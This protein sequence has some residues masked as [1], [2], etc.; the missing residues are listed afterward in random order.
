MNCI[1]N[2]RGLEKNIAQDINTFIKEKNSKVPFDANDGSFELDS[3]NFDK[4]YNSLLDTITD[5]SAYFKDKYGVTINQDWLKLSESSIAIRMPKDVKSK[6]V[7]EKQENLQDKIDLLTGIKN[8]INSVNTNSIN[9]LIVVKNRVDMALSLLRAIELKENGV[10]S[11]NILKSTGWEHTEKSGWI[12][13]KLGNKDL[14]WNEKIDIYKDAKNAYD[15][16]V[17]LKDN[18]YDNETRV[19]AENL[20]NYHGLKGVKVSYSWKKIEDKQKSR[21]GVLGVYFSANNEIV[22]SIPQTGASFETTSIH[23]IIHAITTRAL[24]FEPDFYEKIH[25]LYEIAK[26]RLKDK[27][28]YG[29]KNEHEFVAEALSNLDFIEELKNIEYE[30]KDGIKIN[31]FKKFI[32][33]LL[34]IFGGLFKT[35]ANL[36]DAVISTIEKYASVLSDNELREKYSKEWDVEWYLNQKK[37]TETYFKEEDNDI[38]YMPNMSS[39]SNTID[40]NMQALIQNQLNQ[41]NSYINSQL[42]QAQIVQQNITSQQFTIDPATFMARRSRSKSSV[43]TINEFEGDINQGAYENL[44]ENQIEQKKRLLKRLENEYTALRKLKQKHTGDESYIEKTAKYRDIIKFTKNEIITLEE[45]NEKYLRN[46][47]SIALEAEVKHLEELVGVGSFTTLPDIDDVEIELLEERIDTISK[48]ILGISITGAQA[49][50]PNGSTLKWED[51]VNDEIDISNYMKRVT[52]I[53]N[54][55]IEKRERIIEQKINKTISR[56]DRIEGE[57]N[58]EDYVQKIMEQLRNPQEMNYLLGQFNDAE[59]RLGV[60]GQVIKRVFREEV[61]RIANPIKSSVS[62]IEYLIQECKKLDKNFSVDFLIQ[63]DENG[64]STPYLNGIYNAN[65]R[66]LFGQLVNLANSY[67][68]NVTAITNTKQSQNIVNGSLLDYLKYLKDNFHIFNPAEVPDILSV[69]KNYDRK[70]NTD[71]YH[72]FESI[73]VQMYGENFLHQFGIDDGDIIYNT[74]I[75]DEQKKKIE[76]YLDLI[77]VEEE[78]SGSTINISEDT[79]NPFVFF[80]E[81]E[82]YK[83]GNANLL[84]NKNTID[85]PKIS[86]YIISMP[87]SESAYNKDLKGIGSK[88][89]DTEEEKLADLKGKLWKATRDF[90]VEQINPAFIALGANI[91][92]YEIPLSFSSKDS[93]L[94]KTLGFF[95]KFKVWI[96]DILDKISDVFNNRMYNDIQNKPPKNE[97]QRPSTGEVNRL[98]NERI[99]FLTS[100]K[101]NT[102]KNKLSDLEVKFLDYG[103]FIENKGYDTNLLTNNQKK[104]LQKQYKRYLADL[105]ARKEIM[106]NVNTNFL[107][108]IGSLAQQIIIATARVNTKAFADTIVNYI[109]EIVNRQ[110]DITPA[111]NYLKLLEQWVYRN[112]Y[113]DTSI[114]DKFVGSWMTS[115]VGAKASINKKLTFG[116]RISKNIFS[117][118]KIDKN[119]NVINIPDQ[120]KYENDIYSIKRKIKY[121]GVLS[122]TEE[123]FLDKLPAE[124]YDDYE[125]GTLKSVDIGNET[126]TI[127][128]TFLKNGVEDSDMDY[129][130][131]TKKYAES[132]K[133]QMD[134]Y[135]AYRTV[136]GIVLGLMSLTTMQELGINPESGIRNR[137]EGQ[138]KNN[139]FAAS[140]RYGFNEIDLYRARRFLFGMNIVKMSNS[141]KFSNLILDHRFKQTKVFELWMNNLSIMQNHTNFGLTGDNEKH[142]L[143]KFAIDIPETYNQGEIVLALLGRSDIKIKDING[144]EF[145]IFDTQKNDF[146]IYDEEAAVRGILRLKPEFRTEEN[147]SQW[148]KFEIDNT[149]HTN[150]NLIQQMQSTITRIQ[151]NYEDIDIMPIQ[152]SV[153][154][155]SII[156]YKRWAGSHFSQKFSEMPIDYMLSKTSSRGMMNV[157]NDHPLLAISFL[158]LNSFLGLGANLSQAVFNIYNPRRFF[159]I[160]VK[161]LVQTGISLAAIKFVIKDQAKPLSRDLKDEV[162]LLGSLI[163]EA[164]GR[165]AKTS[166]S[167]VSRRTWDSNYGKTLVDSNYISQEDRAVISELA[168]QMA[169]CVW[170]LLKTSALVLLFE[171]ISELFD[172]QDCTGDDCDERPQ[173]IQKYINFIINAEHMLIID[174]LKWSNPVKWWDDMGSVSILRTVDR[175]ISITDVISNPTKEPEDKWI[176]I[177]KGFPQPIIPNQFLNP[178]VVGIANLSKGNH[179]D[180]NLELPFQDNRIYENYAIDWWNKSEDQKVQVKYNSYNKQLK[181]SATI[182]ANKVIKQYQREN[183][184][185]KPKDKSKIKNELIESFKKPFSKPKNVD[186]DTFVNDLDLNDLSVTAR[187]LARQE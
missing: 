130:K 53:V 119:G 23:E 88:N 172:L 138:Y 48:S 100:L 140:G 15:L 110:S 25:N 29:L 93:E 95:D 173:Y 134:N 131:Y 178:L 66:I 63:K 158:S 103:D 30:D 157:L 159:T 59:Q 89:T 74:E 56:D 143:M 160:I 50:L 18:A 68:K 52:N 121:E 184:S 33:Y 44:I 170:I 28:Y 99:S 4:S 118:D 31:I 120:F 181:K 112:V 36:H 147:I 146:A 165:T 79:R 175:W 71:F 153:V 61:F 32:D 86:D 90:L 179:F 85:K 166:I 186:V 148:E 6:I 76:E 109:R 7:N 151:G 117:K 64:I 49:I 84:T 24:T 137:R 27:N 113:G 162:R 171:V 180:T 164:I 124:L 1:N 80:R 70:N 65:G 73:V 133:N 83:Q 16:L 51:S 41:I 9:D 125:N 156:R 39:N 43:N 69:I 87:I 34:D 5:N 176:S 144:N 114:G 128:V 46:T 94:Y 45:K 72:R 127:S 150:L 142:L 187:E 152:T 116:E 183:G 168:Q 38:Y 154:G 82:L 115:K 47:V 163:K 12:D 92:L 105:I 102:L 81:F 161:T 60:A 107:S 21:K 26:D 55:Y 169:N 2:T 129:E 8:D 108:D 155:K 57:K 98:I 122:V 20:L 174:N 132:V 123:E 10:S 17:K 67:K 141:L 106:P 75:I 139:I 135:G 13:H 96:G 62:E 101:E 58:K 111:K 78:T 136:G 19:I 22:I 185:L 145:P 167:S 14:G 42:Q 3:R 149:N 97:I 177:L 77:T 11:D 126:Y 91:S 40:S 35:D 104:K 54:T 182:Y 37:N